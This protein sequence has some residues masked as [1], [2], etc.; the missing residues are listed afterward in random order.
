MRKV[1]YSLYMVTDRTLMRTLTLEEC[2]EQALAGGVKLVQLR[3][4][5]LEADAFIA[6]GKRIKSICEAY[7]VPLVINDRLDVA[8]G[9]N[10]SGVHIGQD[11]M[12]ASVA[13]AML[14]PERLLGVSV[15][16]VA[17]AIRAQTDGADYLGV[18]AMFRTQ[19]KE[20]ASLVSLKTLGAIRDAV[21]LPIVAIGGMD[22]QTIPLCEPYCVQGF[23]V[24]SALVNQPDVYRAAKELRQYAAKYSFPSKKRIL[25]WPR[26]Q[27]PSAVP[28]PPV[29]W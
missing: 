27:T 10:A 8:I 25:S 16:S 11:D 18:G 20:D 28:I 26:V 23:A 24:V 2:V 5:D 14:G 15:T 7:D 19:T 22:K 17:Q 6:L 12:S 21:T 9:V 29:G 3:E 4:K 13:R 1:E